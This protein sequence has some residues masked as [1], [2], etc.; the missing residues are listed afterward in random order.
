MVLSDPK[1]KIAAFIDLD[2]TLYDGYLWQALFRH[3][4]QFR[5]KRAA[6]Y[7]FIAF[8][9]PLWLLSRGR[10]LSKNFFYQTHAANL[11]WL[12]AG[13]SVKQ[14]DGI[15]RWVIDNEILP[16]LRPEM[17]AAIEKHQ[18]RGHRVI[19]ISGSFAPLLNELAVC[20]GVEAIAT[21]LAVK[22][23]QYTGKIIP[24]LNVGQGK[25]ER[26]KQFLAGPGKEIDLA[27]SYFYTDAI[28]DAPVLEM[29]GYPVVVY[30]DR[31]LANLATARGWLV[32]GSNHKV[33][34]K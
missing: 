15:W 25:V 29:F 6:L 22:N 33:D 4:K 5:F 31:E 19:L 8:H 21:P 26:L 23:G 17:E 14:A 30:P 16:G 20:L 3:H 7:T 34:L 9:L 13:V 12:L 1:N 24:P 10:L 2:G 32:I 18:S 11:A 28:V 27:T